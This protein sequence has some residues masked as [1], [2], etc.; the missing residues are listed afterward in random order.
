MPTDLQRSVGIFCIIFTS[1]K[2]VENG[3]KFIENNK[4]LLLTFANGDDTITTYEQAVG[5]LTVGNVTHLFY[6]FREE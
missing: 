5:A 6:Y 2:Y 4:I 1:V 3:K